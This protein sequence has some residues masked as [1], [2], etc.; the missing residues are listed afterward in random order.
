MHVKMNAMKPTGKVWC[1]GDPAGNRH[2]S[3]DSGN[4]DI[5]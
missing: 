4:A 2:G 3:F 5:Q 1:V